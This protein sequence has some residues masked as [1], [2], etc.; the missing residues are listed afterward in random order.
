MNDINNI[1]FSPDGILNEIAIE[2]LT[3][4]NETSL[5]KKNIY[6]LSSTRTLMD[7]GESKWVN[8]V[9]FG[10]I[11]YSNDLFSD[12]HMVNI[13]KHERGSVNSEELPG[14]LEEINDIASL[15]AKYRVI[16]QIYRDTMATKSAFISLSGSEISILHI[17]THG[18]YIQNDS[19]NI[20][21]SEMEDL[22]MTNSFLHLSFNKEEKDPTGIITAKEIAKLN[23]SKTDLVTLSAC[24]TGL[25][26][27]SLDGVFGLQRGFKKAGV[28]TILM[29][30]W[31]ISDIATKLLMKK[32]YQNII[33]FNQSKV[34]ALHNAKKYLASLTLDDL[35]D[36]DKSTIVND[37]YGEI[38]IDKNA[39]IFASPYY[40]ASFV[41][42]DAI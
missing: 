35:K 5:C 38:K 25:G 27:M 6:R 2:N 9:L 21:S 26:D 28:K 22:S 37:I 20:E 7:K 34:E 11:D 40:W 10:G 32:F 8:A 24:E 41:L 17:A 15:F 13:P 3:K 30:L 42:L 39:K 14:T 16:P 19:I 23:F 12:N 29:S 1:Y 31:P 4:I 33:E 18:Q 36:E